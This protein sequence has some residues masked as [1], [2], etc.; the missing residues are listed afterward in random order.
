MKASRSGVGYAN[1]LNV[2][3]LE[4]VWHPLPT[5]GGLLRD[6]EKYYVTVF[7]TPDAAGCARRGSS[8]C[9]SRGRV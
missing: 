2:V 8:T 3:R 1:A 5:F 9:T 6:P 7:G 4:K